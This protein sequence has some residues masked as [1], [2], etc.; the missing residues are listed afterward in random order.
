MEKRGK[1]KSAMNYA[2][3][4]VIGILRRGRVENI[5]FSNKDAQ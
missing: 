4:K 5:K 1:E 2:R 3:Q